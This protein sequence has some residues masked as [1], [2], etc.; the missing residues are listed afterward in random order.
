VALGTKH[1]GK[2]RN[3]EENASAQQ[4]ASFCHREERNEVE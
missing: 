3:D 4:L 1:Q 2:E